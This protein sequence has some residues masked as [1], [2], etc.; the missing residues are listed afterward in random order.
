MAGLD[1]ATQ[2]H[3]HRADGPWMGGARPPMVREYY[4]DITVTRPTDVS[5][6]IR[7]SFGVKAQ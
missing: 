4:F 2:G 5:P 3:K 6:A 1:P 7:S